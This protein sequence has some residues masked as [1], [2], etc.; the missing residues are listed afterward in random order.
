MSITKGID[1]LDDIGHTVPLLDKTFLT[2]RFF[3]QDN[4]SLAEAVPKI[5]SL[6]LFLTN[7]GSHIETEESRAVYLDY[8]V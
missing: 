7:Q 1:L 6:L 4:A 2:V 5:Q 8:R 3:K